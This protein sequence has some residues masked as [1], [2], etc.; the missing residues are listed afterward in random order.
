MRKDAVRLIYCQNSPCGNT[1]LTKVLQRMGEPPTYYP[2]VWAAGSWSNLILYMAKQGLRELL[3]PVFPLHRQQITCE[4]GGTVSIDWAADETTAA[5]PETAPCLIFLHTISGS[6]PETAYFLKEAARQKWRSCVF[7]RRGNANMPLSSKRFNV[8]GCPHD[9]RHMVSVVQ[10]KYPLSDFMGMVGISAGS[11]LLITYLGTEGKNTPVQAACSLCPAYD[12]STAFTHLSAKY[13]TIDRALVGNM[14]DA[15]VRGNK[16]ILT[17]ACHQLTHQQSI[18]A[19]NKC[20]SAKTVHEFIG[21]S[22]VFSGDSKCDQ[23]YFVKHNP[24]NHYTNITVPTLVLN[25]EDDIVCLKENIRVDLAESTPG[26]ALLL[27]TA[28]SHIAYNEG[29]LMG[30]GN[31]MVRVTMSYLHASRREALQ[32]P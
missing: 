11:G 28:G 9:T 13:P 14:K 3:L 6:G 16:D 15:F 18:E 2:P 4:D 19:Y 22:A 27:T 26:F 31:Y 20:M 32:L 12:I 8:I 29:A 24:M 1:K 7:N 17:Q 25:A 10:N 21:H 23:E 30:H 5:L